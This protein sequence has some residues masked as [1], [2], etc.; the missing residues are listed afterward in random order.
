MEAFYEG[1]QG[2]VGA[3]VPYMEYKKREKSEC[4]NH[5]G[6]S[7]L[8]TVYKI[9]ATAINNR[10]KTYAEDMLRQEQNGFRRN[11]STTENIF[12]MQQ[13][14]EK[15]YEYNIEMYVLFTDFKQAFDSVDRQKTIQILKELRIPN[16]LV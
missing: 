8:N 5:R 2:L 6:I 4:S 13:I 1:G 3:V 14:L 11:M 12:I 9:L 10:L 7:L 15:C 16:R